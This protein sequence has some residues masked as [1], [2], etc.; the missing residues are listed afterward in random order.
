MVPNGFKLKHVYEI[1][2][3]WYPRVT[4]ICNIIAK[5]ALE[6]WIANQPSFVAMERKRE[7]I[8]GW[9]TLIHN[10]IEEMLLDKNP[11]IDRT[12]RPSVDA[13]FD[14]FN[15]NKVKVIDVEKR[16]FSNKDTYA[17]T[18]DILAEINGKLGILDLKTS[19]EIWDNHFIQTAAYFNAYN[20]KNRKKA[21]TH[22][23]LRIDQ[24]NTCKIC[25]AKKRD[26]SGEVSVGGGKR[27]CSHD[28]DNV[29]GSCEMKKVQNHKSFI[30]T[31]LAAKK[32][33]E[34]SNRDLLSRINNYP[35]QAK[36]HL[37]LF[38]V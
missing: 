23:I 33:W 24:F 13:F 31:F 32:L 37:T 38:N 14:W 29:K 11:K 18:F 35:N 6:R 20:E 2:G 27:Y 28:W 15:N 36:T 34:F 9:G 22:W 5:P 19:K 17:G 7:K 1:S 25:G 3:V 26:K 8:T 21:K 12:I 10:T 4:S 30:D 16:I